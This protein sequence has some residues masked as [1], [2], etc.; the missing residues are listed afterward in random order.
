MVGYIISGGV[1][2]VALNGKPWKRPKNY[3]AELENENGQNQ[4]NILL[5]LDIHP[6]PRQSPESPSF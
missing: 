3:V 5:S 1:Q 4:D 6:F 2:P